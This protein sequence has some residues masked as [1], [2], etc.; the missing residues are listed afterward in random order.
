MR[1]EL[2]FRARRPT[3][4]RQRKRPGGG[5][6]YRGQK[7][8]Y[9]HRVLLLRDSPFSGRFYCPFCRGNFKRLNLN[10]MTG[11]RKKRERRGQSKPR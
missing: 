9:T 10:Q 1:T 4:H 11:R 6:R 7:E 3:D 8:C 2:Y 5:G